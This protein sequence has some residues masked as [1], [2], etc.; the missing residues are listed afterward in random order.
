MNHFKSA[1]FFALAALNFLPSF[2]QAIEKR[3]KDETQ[4]YDSMLG[5]TYWLTPNP[6]ATMRI[7]FYDQF[8]KDFD[9][10]KATV[11]HPHKATSFQLLER[12][13]LTP[14]IS[15][16]RYDAFKV[17]FSDGHIQY[18]QVYHF[19]TCDDGG[20]K[21]PLGRQPGLE[22]YVESIQTESPD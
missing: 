7:E 1:C 3:E 11:W 6:S 15:R 20:C 22:K 2:A 8:G 18:V 9:L 19:G 16:H 10:K 13:P 14:T 17:R 12:I 4:F 21:P 5:K